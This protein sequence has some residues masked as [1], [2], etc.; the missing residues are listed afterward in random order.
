VWGRGNVSASVHED[1]KWYSIS[2]EHVI[3][4]FYY[5]HNFFITIISTILGYLIVFILVLYWEL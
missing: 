1:M 4:F 3:F 2:I 5:Y